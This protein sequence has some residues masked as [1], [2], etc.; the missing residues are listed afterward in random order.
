MIRKLVN[1]LAAANIPLHKYS[2]TDP[3]AEPIYRA[4][5]LKE[6]ARA[7]VD[8]EFYPIGSAAI[9][10]FSISSRAR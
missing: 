9:T 6:L 5:F 1:K 4:L 8:D 10:V 2:T 7:G 3:F